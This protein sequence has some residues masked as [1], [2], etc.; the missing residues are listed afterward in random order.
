MTTARMIFPHG[1]VSILTERAGRK[2]RK[3]VGSTDACIFASVVEAHVRRQPSPEPLLRTQLGRSPV[4]NEHAIRFGDPRF[5][6][7]TSRVESNF[8]RMVGRVIFVVIFVVAS[9]GM[10]AATVGGWVRSYAATDVFAFVDRPLAIS[11][12][13]SR[14]R[15]VVSISQIPPYAP[16]VSSGFTHASGHPPLSVNDY[17][18]ATVAVPASVAG[19]EYWS[20]QSDG[21]SVKALVVPWYSITAFTGVLAAILLKRV[22]RRRHVDLEQEGPCCPRCGYDLRASPARC[23]ECGTPR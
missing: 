10:I 11:V 21:M 14:G 3:S 17:R 6:G 12:L 7:Q 5:P 2:H 4:V 13:S 23:P 8:M 20:G 9:A 15:I 19:F 18:P 16:T 22:R 1:L